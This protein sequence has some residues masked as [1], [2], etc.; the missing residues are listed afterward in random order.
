MVIY[1]K[2]KVPVQKIPYNADYFS[3]CECRHHGAYAYTLHI[4]QKEEGHTGSDNKADRVKG[5]PVDK[6]IYKPRFYAII[7]AR[8]DR[9]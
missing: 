6:V 1:V 2:Y 7:P 8:R 4:A 3:H 9:Q 5:G